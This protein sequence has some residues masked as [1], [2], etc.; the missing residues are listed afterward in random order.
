[1][2]NNDAEKLMTDDIDEY[3]DGEFTDKEDYN[4]SFPRGIIAAHFIDEMATAIRISSNNEDGEIAQDVVQ[5][6]PQSPMYQDLMKLTTL[7]KIDEDTIEDT[8][9]RVE[10]WKQY[11]AFRRSMAGDPTPEPIIVDDTAWRLD[12][13][14]DTLTTKFTKEDLFTL[15]LQIFE[16]KLLKDRNKIED[17]EKRSLIRKAETP[18][19]TLVHYHAMLEGSV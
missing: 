16:S 3:G 1:M 4:T 13:L 14:L 11:E 18:L 5:V 2:E 7:E 17:K 19:D 9:Q 6:D 12:N 15:K 8:K 10:E